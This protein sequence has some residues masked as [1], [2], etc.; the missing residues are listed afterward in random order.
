MNSSYSP[1]QL[2]SALGTWLGVDSQLVRDGTYFVVETET[3]ELG[4]VLVGCGGWSNRK[5]AYGSDHRPGRED[6][7]LNPSTDA[8]KIRAFFVHPDWARKGIGTMIMDECDRAAKQAGFVRFEMGATLSG[9]PL[10]EKF[11][12]V[13]GEQLDLPLSNGEKLP[14]VK[15]AKCVAK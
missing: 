10:Y 1:T 7:L 3:S 8:A 11:G 4:A 12:Y 6:A 15:M 14:I 2:E 13:A 5:T 9:I